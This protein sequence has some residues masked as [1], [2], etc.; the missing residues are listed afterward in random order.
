MISRYH[1]DIIILSNTDG[2]IEPYFDTHIYVKYI[3]FLNNKVFSFLF[4][5]AG[6]ALFSLCAVVV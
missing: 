3:Y 1:H 5:W 6:V 2:S 4:I